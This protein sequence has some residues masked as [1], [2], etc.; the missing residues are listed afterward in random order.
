MV[1]VR[2]AVRR[3]EAIVDVSVFHMRSIV[4]VV[5]TELHAQLVIILI[6]PHTPLALLGVALHI[7]LALVLIGP[8]TRLTLVSFELRIQLVVASDSDECYVLD[9]C[10]ALAFSPEVQ[11]V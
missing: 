3:S 6:A 4:P 5:F 1:N 10:C 2:T 7:Q 9:E 11:L 8:H